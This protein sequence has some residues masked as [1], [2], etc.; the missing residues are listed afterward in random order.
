MSGPT[1]ETIQ[2]ATRNAMLGIMVRALALDAV[3]GGDYVHAITL[4]VTEVDSTHPGIEVTYLDLHGVEVA[5]H[6]L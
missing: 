1:F 3:S 6:S 4:K 5:G 2:I